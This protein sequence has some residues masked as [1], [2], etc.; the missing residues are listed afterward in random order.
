MELTPQEQTISNEQDN[1]LGV[2][3][4]KLHSYSKIYHLGHKE[5][6]NL[7]MG[8]VVVEEKVDG[9]QFSFG[10]REGRV[11]FRSRG[12]EIYP[13]TADKLFKAAVDYIV[14]IKDSLVEGWT[15]RGEVLHAPRHNT[16]TYGRTPKHN[17]VIFDV[18]TDNGQ[19]FLAPQGKVLEALK[20]DLETVPGFFHGEIT[21]SQGLSSLLTTESF[22][23]GCKIEG[24]VIKNYEQFGKDK[25]VLMGKWVR[26]DFKEI[27]QGVWK[28]ANPGQGD[29]IEA[30]I[31]VY[32]S[33]ARWEKAAQHLR[34]R[35]ELE[36]APQDIGKLMKE[37]QADLLAECTAEIKEKLY[38]Y[39]LP[40]ILRGSTGGLPE[41]YKLKLIQSQFKNEIKAELGKTDVLS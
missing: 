35:G 22:L 6:A 27:H 18:E 32:R 20:L 9:S 38:E 7:L 10:K 28:K 8:P 39:A 19:N 25:K 36:N 3:N 15:Y 1:Q 26:E 13:E 14:S 2:S 29:I 4:F 40:K 30:M 16:L 11:F 12:A 33:P 5:L 21:D 17:V 31:Q 23:G 34:D 37:A 24:I 41:W